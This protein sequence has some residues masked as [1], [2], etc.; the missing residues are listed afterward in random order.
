LRIAAHQNATDF[1]PRPAATTKGTT[2]TSKASKKFLLMLQPDDQL[3][4]A[5]DP[6]YAAFFEVFEVF[7]VQ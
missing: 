3:P 4:M 1:T 5:H 6:L 7:V 2:K